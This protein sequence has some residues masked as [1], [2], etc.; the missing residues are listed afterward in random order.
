V[1]LSRVTRSV[2]GGFFTLNTRIAFGDGCDCP[3]YVGLVIMSGQPCWQAMK[4]KPPGRITAKGFGNRKSPVKDPQS[5]PS[6][7]P[8]FLSISSSRLLKLRASA[9]PPL[10]LD[11]GRF[12]VQP[13]LVKSPVPS[14]KSPVPRCG[15]LF[16][17]SFL[18]LRLRVKSFAL[19]ALRSPPSMFDVGCSRL[20]FPL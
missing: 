19:A 18:P 12:D 4:S 9:F 8:L 1:A 2:V 5:P 17:A 3:S 20:A 15:L 14:Q 16:F 10:R 11:V 6:S 7:L 13:F